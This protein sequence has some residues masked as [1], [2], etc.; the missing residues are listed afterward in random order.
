MT[1]ED[2]GVRM[3]VF[4]EMHVQCDSFI[5]LF[6][7][8]DRIGYNNFYFLKATLKAHLDFNLCLS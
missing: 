3:S 1:H 8:I 6:S 2:L 4:I 7:N 5:S